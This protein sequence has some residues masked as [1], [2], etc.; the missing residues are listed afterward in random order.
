MK[1]GDCTCIWQATDWPS[2]RFD[3]AALAPSLAEVSR[4]QGVLMGRLA[5]VGKSGAGGRSTGYEL[6]GEEPPWSGP[7]LGTEGNY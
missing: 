7:F 3:L 5:D 4:A 2:W 1:C 6:N